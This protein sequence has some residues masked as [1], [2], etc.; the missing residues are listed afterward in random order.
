MEKIINKEDFEINVDNLN[1]EEI[2]NNIN[3]SIKERGYIEDKIINNF[4][5]TPKIEESRTIQKEFE[6]LNHLWNI[7]L[8]REVLSRNG[9]FLFIKKVIRKL[10]RWYIKP[11]ME[12]QITFNSNI[13]RASN[14]L[15]SNLEITKDQLSENVE[16]TS[17]VLRKMGILEDKLVT[18]EKILNKTEN[19]LANVGKEKN[20]IDEKLLRYES[21]SQSGEDKI[22]EY[23][24][25]YLGE[26][27]GL[28]YLDIGCN[29]YSN[30]SNTYG[31]YRKG[32]RGVLI[33]A[34]PIFIENIKKYRPEDV[35]LNC[36]IGS[37]KKESMTFYITNPEADG[38]SSFD[39]KTIK[40][41]QKKKEFI[42][43]E[44]VIEVPVYTLDDIYIKYFATVPTLVSLDVEGLELDIL[45]ASD[46][47][48][49]RPVIFIVE[50]IDFMGDELATEKRNEIIEFM[51]EKNYIE[52]AFTGINSI[53]ID[54]NRIKKSDN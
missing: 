17:K 51:K 18:F 13:V 42:K 37:Q 9:V 34:N 14:Y 16:N 49:Y 27:K 38:L 20:K 33:D 43:V 6:D 31:L 3:K 19:T 35:L 11:I 53:F 40:E 36:G 24:L 29:H 4:D 8:E 26:N 2:T 10:S 54:E 1:I 12:D 15:K 45:K 41:A 39:L 50:T 44:K 48:K 46:F 23:I 28:T 30:L 32:V 52:Y 22:I 5:F 21:Y 7:N 25:S 47:E